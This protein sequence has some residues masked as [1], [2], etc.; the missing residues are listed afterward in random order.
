[1]SHKSGYINLKKGNLSIRYSSLE[2]QGQPFVKNGWMEMVIS[3]HFLCKDLVHHPIDS[4]PF[5]NGWPQ[6]VPGGILSPLF[7]HRIGKSFVPSKNFPKQS[8]DEKKLSQVSNEKR[9]PGWLGYIGDEIL[10][11]YI[12]IIS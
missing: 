9:A 6:R 4:Q 8:H 7:F 1:M 2:P 12:G 3:N 5:V 10:P 11:S